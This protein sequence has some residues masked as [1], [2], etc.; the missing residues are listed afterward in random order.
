MKKSIARIITKKVLIMLLIAVILLLGGAYFVVSQMVS[1][2]IR[3]H[4]Q[5]IA[6]IFTDTTIYLAQKDNAAINEDYADEIKVVGDYMCKWYKMDAAAIYVPD[7]KNNSIHYISVSTSDNLS[8]TIAEIPKSGEVLFHDFS[9]DEIAVWKGKET[10]A[11]LNMNLNNIHE[12]VTVYCEKDFKGNKFFAAVTTNYTEI[13]NETSK[14]IHIFIGIIA[15]VIIGIYLRLNRI[16]KKRVS[17]PSQEI[18]NIMNSYIGNEDPSLNKMKDY[19]SKEFSMISSAYNSMVDDINEYV[20][21]IKELNSEKTKQAA[22][23]NVASNIQQGF[24]PTSYINANDYYIQCMMKPAKNVGG[25]L[26]DYRELDENKTL[27]VIADVSGKGITASI[28]MAITLVLIREYAK[29]D[30]SPAEILEKANNTLSAKNPGMQFIT[31]FIGIYD[32]RNKAFTYSNA[33]HN[34]PFII[35]DK[36]SEIDNPDGSVLGLFEGESYINKTIQLKTGDTI[37]MYTDGVTEVINDEKEFFGIERLEES[38]SKCINIGAINLVDDIYSTLSDFSGNAEQFDDI[39]MLAL[40]IKDTVVISLDYDIKEF[41][42]V[43]DL[44]LQ[45]P[46]EQQSKLDLCLAAEEI[47]INICNYAFPEGAPADEKITFALSQAD[48]IILRLENGGAKFNPLEHVE[49]DDEYDPDVQIGGL[50]LFITNNIVDEIKYD[51]K[52]NKNIISLIKNCEEK[53][54]NEY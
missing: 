7:F 46:V 4:A 20:K 25:D 37:F 36:V 45:L 47:F 31:A 11:H 40:T 48:T 6:G 22:E 13:H 39:T 23:L 42:K 16:I 43:K 12:L 33:G 15:L 35:S 19:D 10:F 32:R 34:A 51:Y 44:I 8:D 2:D 50:G 29:L 14:H 9:E 21:N 41:A 28:I 18:S 52:D 27:V 53:N 17:D 3:K 24:L 26:Y 54:K 49:L 38:L 1:S 5:T 30:L